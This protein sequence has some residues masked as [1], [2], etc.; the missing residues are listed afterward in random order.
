MFV[1]FIILIIARGFGNLSRYSCLYHGSCIQEFCS[2]ILL[3]L[4][5][6]LHFM[7]NKHMYRKMWY[8]IFCTKYLPREIFELCIFQ[9]RLDSSKKY[10]LDMKSGDRLFV[11]QKPHLVVYMNYQIFHYFT[12]LSK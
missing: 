2:V 10:L 8:V 1:T 12:K 11:P 3:P 4:F 5:Y 6:M 9:R 7:R